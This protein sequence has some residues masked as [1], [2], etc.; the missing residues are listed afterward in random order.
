MRDAVPPCGMRRRGEAGTG[1]R[2]R[3]RRLPGRPRHPTRRSH[4]ARP[5]PTHPGAT[6][7][8]RHGRPPRP[9]A[10]NDP[11][12]HTRE[13]HSDAFA[14]ILRT[15][16]TCPSGP[17]PQPS[18]ST[19]SKPPPNNLP[20]RH[21][22]NPADF[23]TDTGRSRDWPGPV[24]VGPGL[25]NASSARRSPSHLA[26]C[27]PSATESACARFLRAHLAQCDLR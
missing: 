10:L 8:G 9:N 6:R 14:T 21:D 22:Q 11:S 20:R 17:S 1:R 12:H 3:P 2:N 19:S 16:R 24:R 25:R 13:T 27:E 7:A 26:P 15:R 23:R 4:R 18:R 5:P